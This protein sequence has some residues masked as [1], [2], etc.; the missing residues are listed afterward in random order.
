M[1]APPIATCR[2]G[3]PPTPS[4]ISPTPI[5]HGDADAQEAALERLRREEGLTDR[6]MVVFL[7]EFPARASPVRKL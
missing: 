5:P 3:A 6:D 2:L 4:M 1:S 7:V